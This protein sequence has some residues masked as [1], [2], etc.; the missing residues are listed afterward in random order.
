[1]PRTIES[2]LAM[3]LSN[4][5]ATR[6][7]FLEVN[8]KALVAGSD[9]KSYMDEVERFSDAA[10]VIAWNTHNWL[11]ARGVFR[12]GSVRE[13]PD[14]RAQTVE[15][16]LANVNQSLGALVLRHNFRG[17]VARLWVAHI[18]DNGQTVGEPELI[19]QGH[20]SGDWRVRAQRS[21]KAATTTIRTTVVSPLGV[22]QKAKPVRT[23]VATHNEMLARADESIGDRFFEFIPR[24]AGQEI[25]WG[26][27]TLRWDSPSDPG[28]DP[29]Y[30]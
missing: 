19:F 9:P 13:T 10:T 1:M 8:Y 24:L 4:T 14:E 17:S 6:V 11:P 30:A 26:V 28:Q 20:L 2:N 12:I 5:T 7:H 21:D 22:L 16:E 25:V 3:S 29:D 15:L 27:N 23:N 18:G